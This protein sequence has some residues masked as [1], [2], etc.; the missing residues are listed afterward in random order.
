MASKLV[1]RSPFSNFEIILLATN[2]KLNEEFTNDQLFGLLT[3]ANKPILQQILE[4]FFRLNFT[5]IILKW[6]ISVQK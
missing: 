4:Q 5:K 2:P 6:M 3:I 1:Y